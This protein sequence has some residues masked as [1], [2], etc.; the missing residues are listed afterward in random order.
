MA[1]GSDHLLSTTIYLGQAQKLG[2]YDDDS[3]AIDTT[4]PYFLRYLWRLYDV[5]LL[6][7]KD[8]RAELGN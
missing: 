1:G 2:G 8:F 4:F 3:S 7:I 6:A 5:L